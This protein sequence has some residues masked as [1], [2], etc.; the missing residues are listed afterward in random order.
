MQNEEPTPTTMA[1]L[2]SITLP[3]PTDDEDALRANFPVFVRDPL[4][5]ACLSNNTCAL[6]TVLS[7]FNPSIFLVESFKRVN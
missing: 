2:D 5:S 7:S 6:T 4:Q 1:I 3:L